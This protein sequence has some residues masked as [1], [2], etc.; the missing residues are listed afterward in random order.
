MLIAGLLVV[1]CGPVARPAPTL[2]ALE[3]KDPS[4]Y[5]MPPQA[6]A[7]A[8]PASSSEDP[9]SQADIDC[10]AQYVADEE[11]CRT[12]PAKDYGKC[13]T[14]ARGRQGDCIRGNRAR[15]A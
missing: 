8:A 2:P 6:G 10:D 5:P 12:G 15:K 14:A 4:D 11:A 9:D 13:H 3:L 7:P 1:G